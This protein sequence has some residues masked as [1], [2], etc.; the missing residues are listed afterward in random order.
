MTIEKVGEFYKDEGVAKLGILP[1]IGINSENLDR[2]LLEVK[3]N[4][5]ERIFGHPNFGFKEDNL[6]FLQNISHVKQLHFWDVNLKNIDGIYCLNE[7]ESVSIEPKRPGINFSKLKKL[8]EIITDYHKA[9]CGFNELN[10]VKLFHLWNF[11]PKTKSFCELLLP[12]NIEEFE[13][14]KANPVNLEGLQLLEKLK[15]LGIHYCRNIESIELLMEIA[16]NLEKLVVEKCSKLD[17]YSIIKK[18]PSIK[19]ANING[20]TI[21]K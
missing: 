17:K 19:F 5:V 10:K 8:K 2:C 20:K 3:E 9:D 14:T 16:P 18:M 13:I 12:P 4:N 1:S 21:I 15:Y 6:D 11:K 7:L